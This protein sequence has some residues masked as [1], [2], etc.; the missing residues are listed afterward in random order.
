MSRTGIGSHAV[1]SMAVTVKP[2]GHSSVTQWA[3]PHQLLA[4]TAG[5]HT[6]WPPCFTPPTTV[7]NFPMAGLAGL[8]PGI[9]KW[10]AAR[11]GAEVEAILYRYSGFDFERGAPERYCSE[12]FE[13]ADTDLLFLALAHELDDIADAGLSFAPKYGRSIASRVEA[14]ARL[15]DQIGRPELAATLTAHGRL[16]EDIDWV[17]NL[18]STTLRG[19]YIVPNATAYF[20]HRFN[21]L[22]RKFVKLH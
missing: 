2:S 17:D 22:C 10:L 7:D 5:L 16:Y 9:A 18:K 13:E 20:R 8:L 19:F 6:F 21:H 4:S 3:Q 12:G 15:A 1:C 14:C 11:I